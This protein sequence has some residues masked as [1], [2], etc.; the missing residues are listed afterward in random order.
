MAVSMPTY[1]LVVYDN[2]QSKIIIQTDICTIIW[3]NIYNRYKA[4]IGKYD[5]FF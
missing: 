3:S 2:S 4:H 5:Y 1:K